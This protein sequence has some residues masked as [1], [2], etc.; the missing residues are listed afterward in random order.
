[1]L[2]KSWKLASEDKQVIQLRT[3]MEQTNQNSQQYLTALVQAACR[4]NGWPLDRSTLYTKVTPF[5]SEVEVTDRPKEGC[6]A[7]GLYLEG[8]D[9][10]M[11]K[12]CL[13]TSKTKV[14]VVELPIL[15]IIPIKT[16]C[17]GLEDTLRTPVYTTSTRR[18]EMGVG[19]VFEADLCTNMDI[20]DWVLQGVCLCLNT[21]ITEMQ[22][23]QEGEE[24]AEHEQEEP[25]AS[26]VWRFFE[27]RATGDT[28]RRN[29]SADAILEISTL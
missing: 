11:E 12:G 10:D 18:N 9:W 23:D 7:S 2:N 8:A 24:A 22:G 27:E 26:T 16:H 4:K 25:Q 6:F 3:Q 20:S 19:L 28:T 1:M 17:L 13:M 5:R 21:D 14:Q 29:P 15:K